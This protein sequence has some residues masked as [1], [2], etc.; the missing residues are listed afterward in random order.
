M[1]TESHAADFMILTSMHLDRKHLASHTDLLSTSFKSTARTRLRHREER[2]VQ[3]WSE[4]R[5]CSLHQ[6]V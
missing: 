6:G 2:H 1:K 3:T 4:V 5:F